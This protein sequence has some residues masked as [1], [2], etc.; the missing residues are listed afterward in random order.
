MHIAINELALDKLVP[1]LKRLI[2]EFETKKKQF[3]KII[4]ETSG[5]P[6][7]AIISPVK[8]AMMGKDKYSKTLL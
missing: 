8:A 7:K 5:I 1:S 6:A 3:N 4:E 2:K